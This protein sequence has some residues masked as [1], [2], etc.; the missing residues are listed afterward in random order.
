[1][2]VTS[3]P[4]PIRNEGCTKDSGSVNYKDRCE[5]GTA[6]IYKESDKSS[7]EDH[8]GINLV[9]ITSKLLADI[10]LRQLPSTYESCAR[11]NQAASRSGRDCT[12]QI[13]EHRHIFR[14]AKI[15]VF[16][17]RKTASDSVGCE[18]LWRS[19]AG[20]CTKEVHLILLIGEYE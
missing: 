20:E 10:T 2:Q 4:S 9:T 12:D 14:R 8:R 11:G 1:M 3:S 13:L 7:S 5:S 6:S 15:A 16:P 19:L 18:S 17:D